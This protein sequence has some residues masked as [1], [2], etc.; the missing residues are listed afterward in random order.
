MPVGQDSTSVNYGW[1]FVAH[2]VTPSEICSLTKTNSVGRESWMREPCCLTVQSGCHPNAKLS[3]GNLEAKILGY[4][5]QYDTMT[6][7]SQTAYLWEL[8]INET[9]K[10]HTKW[11]LRCFF[12]KI[13]FFWFDFSVCRYFLLLGFASLLPVMFQNANLPAADS[14]FH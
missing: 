6:P 13:D 3:Q 14:Y 9:Q 7:P 1:G 12:Q 11:H 8:G 2:N 4:T 5:S 10:R